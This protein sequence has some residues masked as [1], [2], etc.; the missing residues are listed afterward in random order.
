MVEDIRKALL[1]EVSVTINSVINNHKYS[2]IEPKE[3]KKLIKKLLKRI[4]NK[5]VPNVEEAL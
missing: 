5:Q 1:T 4:I 2:T 3:K